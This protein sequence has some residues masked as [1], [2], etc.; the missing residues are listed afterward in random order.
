MT[1]RTYKVTLDSKNSITPEPV[2]LRQ[3]DKT[4]AVVINA[5]LMDNGAPVSLDSLTPMFKANTADGQAVIADSTGFNVVNASGGEF[6]YQVP[7]AL[8]SVPGKITTAYFSFS[9]ADGSEST[10][11]VAFIIKKAVDIT[12]P[13]ADDYITIIDGTLNSLRDKMDSLQ[14]DF[15][16]IINNYSKGDFYNKLETDSKDGATLSSAKNYT[17][18]SLSGIVALPETFANL[19]EI[20]AKYPSGKNGLMVTADTGHKY[21][22]ANGTWT[23]AGVYQAIG[24]NE[25]EAVNLCTN[26]D[27]SNGTTGGWAASNSTHSVVNN[28]LIN[29]AD[30]TSVVGNEIVYLSDLI[31]GHKYYLRGLVKVTNDVCDYIGLNM[32]KSVEGIQVV[33]NNPING[34]VYDVS[35]M[36]TATESSSGFA[37]VHKYVD[38]GTANGKS[39]ELKYVNIIDISQTF[40]FGNEPNKSQIDEIITSH[41]NGYIDGRVAPFADNKILINVLNHGYQPKNSNLTGLSSLKNNDGLNGFVVQ[42]GDGSFVTRRLI[43]K[44]DQINVTNGNGVNEHPT[45]SIP[46]NPMLMQPEHTQVQYGAELSPVITDWTGINGSTLDSGAWTIPA[47]GAIKTTLSG[48]EAEAEYEIG[49]TW[50]KTND[51]AAIEIPQL[52][53][54]LGTVKTVGQFTGYSDAL[55]K[56]TITAAESGSV[57]L[58]LGD[59]VEDWTATITGVSVKK[60]VQ[61]VTPAGKLGLGKMD[62]TTSG[63][64][65]AIGDGQQKRTSGTGNNSIGLGALANVTVGRYNT[66]FGT[67]ALQNLDTGLNNIAVGYGPLRY[68]KSGYYN[69]AIGY[70]AMEQNI[71]G[72][73]NV[74]IGNESM[75]DLTSG[76][77]NTVVGSRAMNSL[78]TGN[79]NVAVGREA[80]L[81]PNAVS[82]PTVTGSNNVFIGFRSGQTSST[83]PDGAVAIGANATATTNATAIGIGASAQG[84]GSVA[85]GVDSDGTS[86]VATDQNEVVIGTI[87]HNVKVPGKLNIAQYTPLSTV[88]T[89]GSVGDF[90]SDANYIY[91]KTT[92]GWKRSAL[93]TF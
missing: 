91:V 76:I 25:F 45:L 59:G 6:T 77:R 30:G 26:G 43:G 44:T 93:E 23:D 10:F 57:D 54:S 8:S 70:S 33:V 21:I 68:L 58:Q 35:F 31:V 79:Q 48:I 14:I 32:Y 42:T 61:T 27:F 13:Q 51:Y 72:H 65:F 90:T 22:W 19:A 63:D 15:N 62:V 71:N 80:G 75:R 20:Q 64:N 2:F 36:F 38:A 74:A 40:G 11:D 56:L 41:P 37:F 67:Y 81:Y 78:K 9:D 29:T 34:V 87:K 84:T 86:A 18:N 16:T 82:L 28:T 50:T 92:S 4:G 1:I 24:T 3:G 73:W 47:K 49:I 7:N 55:Y 52:V 88:D 66:A 39:M 83:Q 12:K 69:I 5:T 60:V 17:D 85:I 89:Q 46:K 53:A